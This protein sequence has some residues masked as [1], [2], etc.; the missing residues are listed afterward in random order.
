MGYW[1]DSV[2]ESHG[3]ARL[4]KTE[5]HLISRAHNGHGA[6]M[7]KLRTLANFSLFSSFPFFGGKNVLYCYFGEME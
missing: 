3:T 6:H 1:A 5:Y 7:E 4:E 2:I